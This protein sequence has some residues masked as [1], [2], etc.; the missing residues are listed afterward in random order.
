MGREIGGEHMRFSR[1][2]AALLLAVCAAASD[3]AAQNVRWTQ[4]HDSQTG[5]FFRYPPELHVRLRDPQKFGLPRVETI[6]D[7][8]GNTKFNRDTI[9]LRFLVNRGYITARERARKV[10]ELRR[11]C[12]KT[13]SIVVGRHKAVVCVSAGSAAVHWSVEILDPRECTILTLLGGADYR[14]SLP[15]PHDGDF[16]LLSIIRT[17]HFRAPNDPKQ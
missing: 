5:L 12:M 2:I 17:V 4:F 16:P 15:P 10:R 1:W 11:A 13:S 6:V 9:V 14:Q 7:L 3:G 8:I